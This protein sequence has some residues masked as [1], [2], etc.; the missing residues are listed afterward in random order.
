[1]AKKRIAILISGGGSNMVAVVKQTQ[2]GILKDYCEIALVLSN[3]P[4]APGLEKAR[5]LGVPTEVIVSK[6]K[7]REAF[8][9]EVVE[10]LRSLNIDFVVLAGFMRIL[11]P[12]FI[13]AFPRR[14]INIHPADPAQFRGIGGYEWAWEQNLEQTMITVHYV[15]EGVD[16]GQIIAQETVDLKGCRSLEEV[17][18]RGLKVEHALYSQALRVIFEKK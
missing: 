5:A 1:M 7:S 12:F 16:T 8:D 6:G 17:K 10:R 11:S 4:S 18:E 13:Q 14:I 9:R 3:K 15:D 2:T